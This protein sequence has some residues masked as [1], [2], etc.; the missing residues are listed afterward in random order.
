MCAT[1][2]RDGW[3]W[4]TGNPGGIR[5]PG[6]DRPP[7]GIEERLRNPSAVWRVRQLRVPGSHAY[8]QLQLQPGLSDDA[9]AVIGE[10]ILP[11]VEM[12]PE[13]LRG[14]E[15]QAFLAERLSDVI[16]RAWEGRTEGGVS[17]AQ[18]YAVTGFNQRPV[19]READGLKAVLHGDCS[20]PEFTGFEN[21]ADSGVGLLYTWDPEGKLTGVV[22][23]CR[24]PRRCSSCTASCRRISG[25]SRGGHPRVAGQRARAGCAA[26]RATSA[27]WTW[28]G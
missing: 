3:R 28:C 11:P 20:R 17:S 9:E 10:D 14:E 6:Y 24:R 27:R 7:L 25:P 16:R 26:R 22:S 1:A 12:G 19:F 21:G 5:V 8:A 13:V 2:D 15:A 23:T 18:E 4:S